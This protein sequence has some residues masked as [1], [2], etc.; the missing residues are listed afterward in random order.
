MRFLLV[1]VRKTQMNIFQFANVHYCIISLH[2]ASKTGTIIMP[3]YSDI[4]NN[5][6][7]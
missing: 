6:C 5:R 2:W 3:N 7:E 4:K 1:V